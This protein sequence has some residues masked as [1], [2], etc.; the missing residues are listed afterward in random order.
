MQKNIGTN[1]RI[2]R[3]TIAALLFVLAF[4]QKSVILGLFGSF[5]LYEAL[6]SWCILYQ[7]L[8]KNSCEIEKK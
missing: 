7:I 5:V 3:F 4:W 2:I 8:G 1:D 6:S